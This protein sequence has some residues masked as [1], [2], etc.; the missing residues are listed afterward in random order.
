MNAE[1]YSP[2]Y[3]F[4]AD[5]S[6]APRPRITSNPL[7]VNYAQELV[8]GIDTDTPIDRVHV[9]KLSS[10]THSQNQEQRLVPLDFSESNGSL[11]V[12]FPSSRY[13]APPGHYLLYAVDELGVPSVGEILRIGHPQPKVGETVRHNLSAGAAESFVYELPTGIFR[14]GLENGQGTSISFGATPKATDTQQVACEPVVVDG[15]SVC[16]FSVP[17]AGQ[18][19][20]SIQASTATSYVFSTD[21][22]ATSAP[23]VTVPVSPPAPN[24]GPAPSPDPVSPPVGSDLPV[25]DAAGEKVTV[26]AFSWVFNAFLCGLIVLVRTRSIGI[27]RP[28]R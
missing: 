14:V 20:L 11:S 19:Y 8:I 16:E 22:Q 21:L 5:G 4:S 1:I 18:W 2:P 23:P 17:T 27:L 28:R 13:V 3:L 15:V 12:T 10:V 25:I 6:L 26:G 24:P 9:I 7:Q